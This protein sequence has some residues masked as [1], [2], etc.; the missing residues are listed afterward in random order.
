MNKDNLNVSVKVRLVHNKPYWGPGVQDVI[1]G[2]IKGHSL[3]QSSELTGISYSKTRKIIRTAETALETDIVSSHK[4]GSSGG[5][6]SVTDEGIKIMEFYEELEKAIQ[7]YADIK[8]KELT[9]KFF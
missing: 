8:C 7:E 1:K 2:I 5:I 6:S 3:K 4:G 9:D